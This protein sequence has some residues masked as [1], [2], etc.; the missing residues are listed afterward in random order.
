[1]TNRRADVRPFFWILEG[2]MRERSG[3]DRH[4]EGSLRAMRWIYRSV[5]I[6]LG[7][8][9]ASTVRGMGPPPNEDALLE[10][11]FREYLETAFRLEP[12]MATRL[13][14]HRFDDQLDDLRAPARQAR[15]DHDR[16]ALADLS[17]KVRSEKLSPDRRIDYEIVRHHLERSIWLA[18]TFQPFEDDP[19]VYG[20]YLTESVYLLLTQSSLPAAINIKN[21]LSR[22]AQIPQ[23]VEIA[24]ST[25]KNPPRVKV[26]TAIKQTEGA[27]AF[28]NG[29]LL[30]LASEG[31]DR[32]ALSEK[33][34][35]IVSALNR[36]LNFLNNEVLPRSHDDWRIGP[37]RFAQKIELELDAGLSAREVR[38]LAEREA[39]RVESEMAVIA[40][41]VWGTNFPDEP[42]P[43]DD[44]EGRRTLIKRALDVVALDQGTAETLVAD[45]RG[46]VAE[47]KSFISAHK[48][49]RLIEPDRC[50]IVEMPEFLRGNSVA[51]LNPA[52]PLDIQGSSEYAISP[53]PRQWNRRQ[54]ES[55]LREYNRAML[56]ILTIHEGYPGHYVQLE[57]SNRCPSLIRRVLSSGTFA[58]GWAVYT[59]QMM[60]D[61]GFGRGDLGLR[62]QQ[63]KFYLRAVVN[64]ILDHQMHAGSM[65]DAQA[66]DLLVH[67]AF[68]TEGE[69]LGK[70]I[71][72]K[73]TSCQLSTYFVGRTAFYRLR[74][75]LQ[76]EG[77]S[78]FDLERYH[79]AVLAQGTIPVKYLPWLVRKS[80]G[81]P[82]QGADKLGV[83]ASGG[84]RESRF[85][86][87]AN[88]EAAGVAGEKF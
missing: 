15:L 42:L 70:I 9:V 63:L 19:R 64:A 52:P 23:I 11:F 8:V 27:I 30:K 57:H 82:Q 6:G 86:S 34:G 76:R 18:E 81:L 38:A 37:D 84:G 56:K 48:L 75:Q 26:E 55:Y 66:M 49:L 61:Q 62:L 12:M 41:Q 33:A 85:L 78:G 32:H 5:L 36:H 73:Q 87:T 31:P 59:E 16:A 7:L 83:S 50:R 4:H 28:Y 35:P 72:A 21:A 60:L 44:S 43:L 17:R 25:I 24:R 45:V 10:S 3:F 22:M 58:E 77:G 29:D 71:R 68:Q 14:D 47:I 65:T 2:E 51:Y 1:V 13:G 67:R 54:V 88:L 74:Q 40:R 69:A 46:T 79:E 80:L 20:E 39:S 53:P